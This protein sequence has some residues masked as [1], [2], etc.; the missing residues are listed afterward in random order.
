MSPRFIRRRHR[1]QLLGIIVAGLVIFGMIVLAFVY[2]PYHTDASD[3]AFV[4]TIDG[5][6]FDLHCREATV[7]ECLRKDGVVVME[8]DRLVPEMTDVLTSGMHVI[9]RR[10]LSVQVTNFVGEVQTIKTHGNKVA[11]VLAEMQVVLSADQ[12]VDPDV[13]TWL[14]NDMSIH[15][16]AERE[17]KYQRTVDIAFATKTIKDP[18]LV[19]G[20]QKV[21]TAGQKGEKE[22]TYRLIYSGDELKEKT[23]LSST[24]V[25]DPVTE[26]VHLGT[27]AP[28]GEEVIETGK[29][30]FYS[31]SLEGGRTASGEILHQAQMVAAHKTLPFG[32]LVRVTNTTNNRSV[33]VRIIDRGPY[34]AG[35]VIDL[36]AGAFSE[37]ATLSSGLA[38]VRLAVLK[39]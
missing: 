29:A 33:V 12:R 9:V 5:A 6:D 16:Y 25:K 30:S 14:Q 26:V 11:D 24:V 15:L 27:K 1:R 3:K 28:E 17:E 13:N 8:Y 38:S 34:V 4:L 10:A 21:V 31:P 18:T 39:E 36:S 19:I 7:G 32:T 20:K 37:I 35:R 23:L 2:E 22:E